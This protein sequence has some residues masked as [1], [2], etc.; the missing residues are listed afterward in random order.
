M[1]ALVFLLTGL[2][3][4]FST[5][6]SAQADMSI[7]AE[8]RAGIDA[9][10]ATIDGALDLQHDG[11]AYIMP[12]PKSPQAAWGNPDGRT[13]WYQGYWINKQSNQT[14]LQVPAK[15][16]EGHYVGDGLGTSE[17]KRGGSPRLPTKLEWLCSISGGIPPS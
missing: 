15:G 9:D 3:A 12:R 7:P 10:Q 17:W 8:L 5:P 6:L 11:W 14:S 16:P 13:T 4:I 1:K 2:F